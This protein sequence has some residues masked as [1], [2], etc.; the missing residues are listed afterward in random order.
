MDAETKRPGG[1]GRVRLNADNRGGGRQKLAKFCGRLLWMTHYEIY[2]NNYIY[3]ILS[4][5]SI[6]SSYILHTY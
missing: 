6:Y 3:Y 1:R 2:G 4:D 5:N